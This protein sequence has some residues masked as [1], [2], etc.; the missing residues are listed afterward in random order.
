MIP[1][2]CPSCG[3]VRTAL[4]CEPD[5][6][7]CVKWHS[8]LN[9]KGKP[10]DLNRVKAYKRAQKHHCPC[11]RAK[12]SLNPDCHLCQYRHYWWW[13][14]GY[15]HTKWIEYRESR[16]AAPC[17]ECPA[18][19]TAIT[20]GCQ[21]CIERTRKSPA[22]AV[23]K[24]YADAVFSAGLGQSSRL[25]TCDTCGAPETV[26]SPG[27][28]T[29]RKRHSAQSSP[30]TLDMFRL[31]SYR[32]KYADQLKGTTLEP[33]TCSTCA[34]ILAGTYTKLSGDLAS[35]CTP[36][37]RVPVASEY[38]PTPRQRKI[39]RKR[40]RKHESG[41]PEIGRDTSTP[42]P[43]QKRNCSYCGASEDFWT[44]GCPEC[45][46]RHKKWYKGGAPTP[47]Q[48]YLEYGNIVENVH[49]TCGHKFG[50]GV[51]CPAPMNLYMQ[52]CPACLAR[53]EN[54]TKKRKAEEQEYPTPEHLISFIVRYRATV[55]NRAWNLIDKFPS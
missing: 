42:L 35:R 55:E 20:P 43:R 30:T 17:M 21:T 31:M 23:Y 38:I 32:G 16:S 29:C 13:T 34:N 26:F 9:K 12:L 15:S 45:A 39:V 24:D 37:Y 19:A 11:G 7:A 1:K 54:R 8:G 33:P 53:Y 28:H 3:S 51:T 52:G 18:Q 10:N 46:S 40:T 2:T 48:A 4:W 44:R 5:C 36:A 22:L 6:A 41:I 47:Y 27:C 49:T 14:M 25:G 50:N